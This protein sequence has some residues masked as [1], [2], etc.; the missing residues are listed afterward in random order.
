MCPSSATGFRWGA[1]NC[2]DLKMCHNHSSFLGM[3]LAIKILF[4]NNIRLLEF[5][6]E[7]F[8]HD[9]SGVFLGFYNAA[10]SDIFTSGLNYTH[11]CYSISTN[12]TYFKCFFFSSKE[13][14]Q[15]SERND[16]HLDK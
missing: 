8:F 16:L 10:H 9:M 13:G 1:K 4:F 2:I 11:A 15:N 14:K 7:F 3:N 12:S 6:T 5:L